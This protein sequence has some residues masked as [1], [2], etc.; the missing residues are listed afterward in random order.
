MAWTFQY[1]KEREQN[2]VDS[3]GQW[4][5]R[6]GDVYIGRTKKL[7]SSNGYNE[8]NASYLFVAGHMKWQWE[9]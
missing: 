3:R 1:K 4:C 7:V 6:H 9:V 2:R 8:K 5:P